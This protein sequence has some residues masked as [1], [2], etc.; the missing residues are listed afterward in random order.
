MKQEDAYKAA[1]AKLEAYIQ[2]N[3]LRR[4]PEREILLKH[5][6]TMP[7]PFSMDTLVAEMENE[8]I[9]TGTVYNTVNLLVSAQILHCISKRYGRKRS[10][11]ELMTKNA[12]RMELVCTRCGRVSHFRDIAVENLLR[13]RKYSNFNMQGCSLYVYGTCK[14]CKR[15]TKTEK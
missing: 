10:E 3:H 8:H 7:Q 4:T 12:V 6:C 11:Y 14:T 5:I 13:T 15:K 1:L 2:A 9:S